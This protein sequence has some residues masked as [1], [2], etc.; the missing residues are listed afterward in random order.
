MINV[1]RILAIVL[2]MALLLAVLP[3]DDFLCK[4]SAAQSSATYTVTVNTD[5]PDDAVIDT[6]F[7]YGPLD[8]GVSNATAKYTVAEEDGVYTATVPTTGKYLVVLSY[9]VSTVSGGFRPST[10][11]TYYYGRQIFFVT[12]TETP[13]SVTTEEVNIS[14]TKA[15]QTYAN[16]SRFDHVDVRVYGTYS[17]SQDNVLTNY[18]V[19]LANATVVVS[20]PESSANASAGFEVSHVGDD[21][22]SYEWRAIGKR[23]YKDAIITLTCDIIDASTGE[24]LYEG[25]SVSFSGEVEFTQAIINCDMNQGLDFIINP[26]SIIEAITHQVSY[27]WRVEGS[28]E[29][30]NAALLE[31]LNLVATAPATT[32]GYRSGETHTVDTVWARDTEKLVYLE[33][34]NGTRT[35]YLL[36]FHG[37]DSY[38][39]ETGTFEIDGET[40]PVSSD[41]LVEGY[42]TYHTYDGS[43][44]LTLAKT[45]V[46]PKGYEQYFDLSTMYMQVSK[47]GTDTHLHI[48]FSHMA[49]HMEG[50][51]Q[52]STD[53]SGNTVIYLE[54][55]LSLPVYSNG[56]EYT[57]EEVVGQVPGFA[58]SAQVSVSD[59]EYLSAD[60]QTVSA[61]ALLP[62]GAIN[63]DLGTIAFTNTYTKSQAVDSITR[64]DLVIRK[65]DAETGELMSGVSFTLTPAS[66]DASTDTWTAL[67]GAVT[68]ITNDHGA[69]AFTALEEGYYLLT[70]TATLEGYYLPDDVYIV[71]VTLK[72]GYPIDELVD[73]QWITV[74][75]YNLHVYL[76]TDTGYES[77]SYLHNYLPITNHKIYGAL[78][79][80]KTFGEGNAYLPEA[81][82]VLVTGPDGYSETVVLNADNNWTVTLSSLALGE[83][84]VEETDA[85]VEGYELSVTG[86]QTVALSE[87]T[88]EVT[89]TIANTYTAVT[90]PD[91]DPDPNPNDPP[92]TGDMGPIGALA[93][94]LTAAAVLA[95]LK[96]KYNA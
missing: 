25:F 6:F 30:L 84:S 22:E 76:Q 2:S 29:E 67:S 31:K 54:Y 4:A 39:N 15:S 44:S 10:Y 41:T 36:T 5:M 72:D 58:L 50:G 56:M 80:V 1:K 75:E 83:Y 12:G 13:V 63:T 35:Y 60:A 92:K 94:M 59:S 73:G 38:T 8:G 93:A 89:V 27:N 77:V 14:W 7:L 47:A 86:E 34:E 64:P 43:N 28:D 57:V 18:N 33:N 9:S 37:W 52:Y 16:T 79:I 95:L 11:T 81:I 91:P 49:E 17:T 74:Y 21:E 68:A 71:Q 19:K 42:W 53:E 69:V 32:D 90:E 55:T 61:T 23:I 20:Y 66:Y 62:A 96:K 65:T 40:L 85:E 78:T 24:A 3:A 48:S 45:L 82:T 87:E 88:L 26:I 46:I 51:A 70:E